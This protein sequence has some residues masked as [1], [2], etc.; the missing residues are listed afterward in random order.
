MYSNEALDT[1]LLTVEEERQLGALNRQNYEYA[2]ERLILS[3]LRL[4]VSIAKTFSNYGLELSDLIGFGNLGL[5]KAVNRFD[6]T[7]GAKFST[8][9]SW[10]IKQA[11]RRGLTNDAATV[12]V[13]AHKQQRLIVE[14]SG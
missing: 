2:R 12:R 7:R 13:P 3:N 4:V 11:R 6:P 14:S 9:A 5:I 10:W 1:P 8:Y